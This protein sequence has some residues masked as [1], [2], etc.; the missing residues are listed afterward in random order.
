MMTSC[1]THIKLNNVTGDM[2]HITGTAALDNM[3]LLC[4]F[5]LRRNIWSLPV[6]LH[7]FG[8]S[9][10]CLELSFLRNWLRYCYLYMGTLGLGEVT[11]W[12]RNGR[13]TTRMH[14]SCSL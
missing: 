8:S 14:G 10:F 1:N 13:V 12:I 9:H 2:S 7:V 11:V 4:C 5:T 3:G 6:T